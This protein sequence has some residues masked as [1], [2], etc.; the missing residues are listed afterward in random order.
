MKRVSVRVLFLVLLLTPILVFAGC[1]SGSRGPTAPG[2]APTPTTM[3]PAAATIEIQTVELPGLRHDLLNGPMPAHKIHLNSVVTVTV[4]AEPDGGDGICRLQLNWLAS[5]PVFPDVTCAGRGKRSVR[6]SSIAESLGV[7]TILHA[8]INNPKDIGQ[9]WA[10]HEV[11]VNIE[12]V[13]EVI[14]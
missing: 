10:S 2:S 6:V 8:R 1:D 4:V 7:I 5:T 13:P 3:A 12:V 9:P 14:P 11:P